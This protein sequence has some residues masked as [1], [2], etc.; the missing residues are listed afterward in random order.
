MPSSSNNKQGV[1]VWVTIL[2]WGLALFI[3]YAFIKELGTLYLFPIYP[4]EITERTILSRIWFDFPL[5]AVDVRLCKSSMHHMPWIWYLPGSINWLFF[6]HIESYKTLRLIGMMNGL[7]FIALLTIQLCYSNLRYIISQHQKTLFILVVFCFVISVLGIG[8]VPFALITNRPE[9]IIV[10]FLVLLLFLFHLPSDAINT[11]CKKITVVII[12]FIFVSIILHTHAKALYLSPVLIIIAYR[13]LSHFNR[14]IYVVVG[15]VLLFSLLLY[16]YIAWS[17]TFDCSNLTPINELFKSFNINPAKLIQDP[18]SFLAEIKKSLSNYG[19]EIRQISFQNQTDVGY[20]P[21]INI[22]PNIHLFN[23]FLKVNY[24]LIF[25][26]L[27]F[28]LVISY[29]KD[30]LSGKVISQ[31]FLLLTL[32]LCTCIGQLLCNTK[33]WY[34]ASYFWSTLIIVFVFFFS[35]QIKNILFQKTTY[36]VVAY[37]LIVG[38]WSIYILTTAYTS[39]FKQGWKGPS[40]GLYDYDYLREKRD[41]HKISAACSI[42]LDTAENLI[43]DDAT[44]LHFQKTKYPLAITYLFFGGEPQ[45]TIDTLL[46]KYKIEGMI[47]TDYQ[48]AAKKYGIQVG[49]YVCFTPQN[50]RSAL[51]IYTGLKVS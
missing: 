3:L 29:V 44:Y 31:N 20:L 41:L 8:V 37:F 24:I 45:R 27:S 19:K 49:R 34:D 15:L 17:N 33:N 26:F 14:K 18:S 7:F 42:N 48:G 16:N 5:L 35:R 12:Y 25:C 39:F 28:S 10:E 38:A 23:Q 36:I 43:V 4:D 51:L 21:P 6:S 47:L 11:R 30:L 1:S 40:V 9:Q 2:F 32:L 13:L 50:I 46:S 22:T